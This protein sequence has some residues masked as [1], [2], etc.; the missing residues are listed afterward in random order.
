[1]MLGFQLRYHPFLCQTGAILASP[2]TYTN[3]DEPW[4]PTSL[5]SKKP[6]KID[7][8]TSL[9]RVSPDAKHQEEGT[10]KKISHFAIKEISIL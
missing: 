1:M 3:S 2:R 4:F 7:H 9:H 5:T 6:S 8:P 10:Q